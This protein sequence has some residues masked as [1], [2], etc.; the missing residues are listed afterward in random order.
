MAKPKVCLLVIDP[1]VDFMEGGNL[2]VVGGTADMQRIA[3]MVQKHG[4]DIDEI[5]MTLDSHY[6]IHIAHASYWMDKK[7]N[8]PKPFTLISD[9]DIAKGIWTPRNPAHNDWGL[10][11]PGRL[12]ANGRF[13]LCIWPDHCIIGT[14]GQCIQPDFLAAVTDWE[15][16]FYG[17]APRKTKGSCPHTEHYSA[18]QADV[19]Y[20][21]DPTTRL[22]TSFIDV[23]KRYD[24][25]IMGGEASSHCLNFTARDILGRFSADQV[26]KTYLLTDGCSPVTGFEKMAEDFINEMTAKGMNLTTTTTFFN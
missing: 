19:E 9:E 20:P 3:R 22:D 8:S 4:E 17:M 16:R 12:K 5:R 14:P 15:S 1:Q 2:A 25:I 23:L 11:Y 13:V 21:G 18:V 6:R 7:G 24:I 26:K 10:K